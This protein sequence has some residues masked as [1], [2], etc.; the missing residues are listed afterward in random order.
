MHYERK[1][2]TGATGVRGSLHEVCTVVGC[3]S[4]RFA[5]GW[6]D[7]HY[8]RVLNTGTPGEPERRKRRN[9]EGTKDKRK[10]YITVYVSD[11]RRMGEHRFV[12]EQVLD[13]KLAPEEN[14]HHKNGRRDD[15]RPDNLELWVKPQPVGQ[16]V[17]DL[18][19]WVVDLYPSYVR[20]AMKE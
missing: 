17:E 12:M 6:C 10:G 13:R 7:M 5:R 11:G 15:N 19:A 9:G 2:R 20:A 4:P 8:Q 1:R 18:V 16:R 3:S 14:V